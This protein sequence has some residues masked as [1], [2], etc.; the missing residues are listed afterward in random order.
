MD[1]QARQR[2]LTSPDFRRLVAG[3]WRVA[4]LLTCCLFVLYYGFI[5]LIALNE[6]IV[7]TR[8]A[9]TVPLGIPLGAG[10]IVGAW[11]LTAVYVVWANRRYDPEVE[12]L[13]SGAGE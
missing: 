11:A 13:R 4:L 10:V 7:T 9:G 2:L 3:R 5:L 1:I 6:S 8:V 12:R